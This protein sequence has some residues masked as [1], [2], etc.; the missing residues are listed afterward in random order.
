MNVIQILVCGA[1]IG[2]QLQQA[3]TNGRLR[4]CPSTLTI[5]MLSTGLAN[6]ITS[7]E[8]EV[9]TT[10]HAQLSRTSRR[11][12]LPQQHQAPPQAMELVSSSTCTIL[13]VAIA[14]TIDC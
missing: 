7:A 6:M 10:L 11:K 14:L 8:L 13:A 9:A 1:S 5:V 2:T 4:G 3:T 12:H